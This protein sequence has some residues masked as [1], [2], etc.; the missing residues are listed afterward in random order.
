VTN[1]LEG[2]ARHQRAIQATIP[3][4]DAV[5]SIAE[6]AYREA[7]RAL[8]PLTAYADRVGAQLDELM[9][10]AGDEGRPPCLMGP[11]RRYC[12]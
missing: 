1:D 6:M 2:L 8:P 7:E 11:G 3:R 4:L 9:G 10:T 5:R 12:C